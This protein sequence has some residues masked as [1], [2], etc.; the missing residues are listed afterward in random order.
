VTTVHVVVPDGIDDPRRPSGGNSYDRRLCR[1]LEASGW[2]VRECAVPGSWPRPDAAARAAAACLLAHIPDDAVV[3]L[4]GLV[5]CAIPEV[6]LP[7]ADRLR[8][9]VLVHM[10]LG[11]AHAEDEEVLAREGA[12]LSAAAAAVT[13]SA[14]TRDW[15]VRTYGL[16]TARVHVAVPGADLASLA[17]GTDSGGAL[18]C[19][20][21]LSPAKGHDVLLT[22]L[23]AVADRPWRCVCVGAMTSEPS[24]VADLARRARDSGIADRIRF[25]GPLTAAD[26]EDEYAAADALVQPSLAETYGMV[27]TEALAR[28]VPVIATTAGGLPEAL[29]HGT[30]LARPGLLVPPGDPIA[31]AAALRCWLEDPGLRERLRRTSHDRRRTL[32]TWPDT[33]AVVDRVLGGLAP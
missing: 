13:T 31:L 5:A 16:P 8:L 10:P 15:L 4:D 21:A 22:A 6:L 9:V 27:V 33:V 18:L 14:W 24:F 11:A 3:L 12:T 1:E 7:E 20:G 29:G 28:G 25:T 23:A 32:P 2:S 19:V 17:P 30:G 26:L